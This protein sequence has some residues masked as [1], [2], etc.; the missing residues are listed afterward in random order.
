MVNNTLEIPSLHPL[1]SIL[2]ITMM[3]WRR[4]LLQCSRSHLPGIRGS[5]LYPA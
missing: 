5:S 3:R 4:I 1:M 2:D